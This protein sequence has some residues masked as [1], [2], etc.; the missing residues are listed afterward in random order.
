MAK[1]FKS[2]MEQLIKK[3][4]DTD[5]AYAVAYK[6][7]VAEYNELQEQLN[8]QNEVVKEY[9]K[10]YILDQ[11]TQESYAEQKK[12]AEVIEE[13]LRDA[14]YK[15]N[16][17]EDYRKED[18]R[19]LLA[20][21]EELKIDFAKEVS[22]E[23]KRIENK[24]FK[25]KAVYLKAV[26]ELGKDYKEIFKVDSAIE[27]I[28]VELGVRPYNYKSIGSFLNE[29]KSNPYEPS[30]MGIDINKNEI[31]NAFLSGTLPKRLDELVK[32]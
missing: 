11:I 27:D 22:I 30:K 19:A 18:A 29:L 28:R 21:M 10:L 4:N 3:K 2:Q 20:Q 7:A 1:T 6:K 14:G 13:K 24:I 26:A 16:E 8:Q 17:I 31:D 15:V 23:R 5:K 12:N 9:H 25:A 32:Q